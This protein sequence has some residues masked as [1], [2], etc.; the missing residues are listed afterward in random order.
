MQIPAALIDAVR[1]R[2]ARG[3]VHRTDLMF[4]R[5]KSHD[6]FDTD[7]VPAGGVVQRQ[8][9]FTWAYLLR[10]TLLQNDPLT[11][12]LVPVSVDASVVGFMPSREAAPDGP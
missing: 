1:Q 5:S 9:R 6:D 10:P 7:G 3:F 2:S 12:K 11:G 8:G 4:A